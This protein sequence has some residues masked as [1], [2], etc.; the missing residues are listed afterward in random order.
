MDII[1]FVKFVFILIV[2]FY[3]VFTVLKRKFDLFSPLYIFPLSYIFYLFLGSLNFLQGGYDISPQQWSLYL[4]GLICFYLGSFIPLLKTSVWRAEESKTERF[5]EQNRLIL[6]VLV[7]FCLAVFARMW[8]YVR[9]GI[10]LL[11]KNIN[12]VRLQASQMGY[13]AELSM[14]TEVVFMLSFAGLI[15]YRKKRILFITLILISL[16][17]SLLTGTRTSLIRQLFPC[18]ILYHYLVRRIS[19]KTFGII[20]LL[21]LIFIGSMGLVRV[22]SEFGSQSTMTLKRENYKPVFYWLYFVLRDFK[23][24]PTGLA[25]VLEM[26]PSKFGYQHGKLHILPLLMPLPGSQPQPGVIF[27]N[28]A[29]LEFTGVGMAATMLAVQYADFGLPGIILGMFFIGIL[30]E[31]TYLLAR[32]KKHPFY[33]LLY[34]SLFITLI[35]GIRTD[36][37]NFEIIW[38]I[39]L[40]IVVHLFAGKRKSREALQK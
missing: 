39:L 31:Y 37:L 30:F 34:G 23:H 32:R 4:I 3:F 28:M 33:Y 5:W 27:K 6:F 16:L 22:Y 29:G 40:L 13:L 38:T 18:I 17:F 21:S 11:S 7:I 36:Y 2:F 26:I 24:G 14:S 35:L 12:I 19:I 1:L 10:P 25:R 8:I 15:L 20:V 9:S